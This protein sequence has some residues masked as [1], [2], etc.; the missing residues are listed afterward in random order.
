MIKLFIDARTIRPA[1]TGVGRSTYELLKALAARAQRSP[2][3]LAIRA[4]LLD[5]SYRAL[6]H[7]PGFE[8]VERIRTDLDYE[9]HPRGDLGLRFSIP[10]LIRPGEI[11]HGPAF[12]VPG[13][14]QRFGRVVT[15]HDLGVFLR[16]RDYRRRFAAYLRWKIRSSARAADHVIVPSKSVARELAEVLG[17]QDQKVTVIAEAPCAG[18]DFGASESG[19]NPLPRSGSAP[20]RPAEPYF[21]SVGTLEPRKGPEIVGAALEAMGAEPGGGE[22]PAQWVWVGRAGLGAAKILGAIEAGPAGSRFRYLGPQPEAEVSDLLRGAAALIFPSHYE[23]F[24]LPPLEAMATG[25]P[26]VASDLPVLREV[27]GEA[28]LYFPPGDA[29]ALGGLLRRLLV[30]PGLS[31]KLTAAGRARSGEFSWSRAAEAHLTVYQ[32]VQ[33]IGARPPGSQ[34]RDISADTPRVA[35]DGPA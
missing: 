10:R 13:G 18:V 16:P 29:R 8:A 14:R 32:E 35:R 7:Q 22:P 4:L 30:E 23:G 34:V 12:A 28:A 25:T 6:S 19:E 33:K 3:S 31:G 2:V 27:C 9:S 24:G 1:M 21:L 15:I 17:V 20:A 5:E 11:Y 26:V